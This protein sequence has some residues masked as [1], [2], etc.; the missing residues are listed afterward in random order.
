MEVDASGIM[1]RMED[2]DVEA[3]GKVTV[4]KVLRK[5]TINTHLITASLPPQAPRD[6]G[7]D[8]RSHNSSS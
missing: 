1:M 7:S 5:R 2:G 3:I 8:K 6:T 4:S